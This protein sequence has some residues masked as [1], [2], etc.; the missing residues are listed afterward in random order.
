MKSS[1]AGTGH[2]GIYAGL[3]LAIAFD[4][5]GQI[6]WKQAASRLPETLSPAALLGSVLH[7]PLL[8][9]VAGVFALQLVNWL[10]VLERADLSYVQPI[11]SLS[12]VSVVLFSLW[13]L[14]ERLDGRRA[15]GVVL[16]LLGV[17]MVGV[18]AA[19]RGP[20]T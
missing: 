9:V 5:V 18:D 3:A 4:T 11:T 13:L 6:V 15:V 17:G 8:L 14:E 2:G 19:R 1:K 16:V 20:R 12:Y 7:E 10:L